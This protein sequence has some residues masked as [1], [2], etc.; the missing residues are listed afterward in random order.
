MDGRSLA[1]QD[2]RSHLVGKVRSHVRDLVEPWTGVEV[3]VLGEPSRRVNVRIEHPSLLVQLGAPP[4][5]PSQG[6]SSGPGSRPPASLDGVSLLHEICR[7]AERWASDVLGRGFVAGVRAA[8]G[9]VEHRAEVF[10]ASLSRRAPVMELGEVSELA[11][12]VLRWWARARVA[13]SW[14]VPPLRPHVPCPEC[15]VWDQLRV[16]V[17]PTSAICR[18][19]GAAWDSS[20]IDDLGTGV[21]RAL[22]LLR[23]P[24]VVAGFVDRGARGPGRA[25]PGV[26]PTSQ[27]LL[28]GV[29]P[30]RPWRAEEEREG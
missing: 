15:G 20:T 6:G 2:L 26:T 27:L 13:T 17:E 14:D 11:D 18:E 8:S 23:E 4:D 22:E 3:Q 30:D 25:G 5:A 7:D 21:E 1:D 29:G 10:L 16:V 19:C 24:E 28:A 12:V 9:V